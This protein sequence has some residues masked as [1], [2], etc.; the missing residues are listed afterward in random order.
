MG[1]HKLRSITFLQH[2]CRHPFSLPVLSTN[3]S[4]AFR[5]CCFWQT[6]S[7][8]S[9]VNALNRSS[10]ETRTKTMSQDSGKFALANKFN[11]LEKSVWVEFIDLNAKLNPL[12]LGQGFPDFMPAENVVKELAKCCEKEANPLLHQYTRSMGHPRLVKALA[13][14]YSRLI[15][16]EINKMTEVLVSGGAYGS[17]FCAVMS[18]VGP[19]DEVI[20]INDG[21]TYNFQCIKFKTY[22]FLC[23]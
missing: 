13:K 14:L 22:I 9:S 23:Q 3:S 2:L 17:L 21:S 6:R 10:D 18:N 12:N 20:I 1:S 16:R 11:G 15:G 8:S 5:S 19:G 4:P 7:F